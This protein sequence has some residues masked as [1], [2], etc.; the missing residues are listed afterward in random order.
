MDELNSASPECSPLTQCFP[1]ESRGGGQGCRHPCSPPSP[2]DESPSCSP[3]RDFWGCSWGDCTHW[4]PCVHGNSSLSRFS[5]FHQY[6][7]QIRRWNSECLA[8]EQSAT[9]ESYVQDPAGNVLQKATLKLPR[10]PYP[11]PLGP[12]SPLHKQNPKGKVQL[13]HGD[14]ATVL[15]KLSVNSQKAFEPRGGGGGRG[16]G[17]LAG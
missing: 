6:S 11:S 7:P 9:A 8:R 15:T 2:S 5:C 10:P 14:L 13:F 1:P 17:G 3:R 12:A 16:R 4:K